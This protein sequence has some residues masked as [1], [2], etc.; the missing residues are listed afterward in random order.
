M[1]SRK[2]IFLILCIILLQRGIKAQNYY[3]AGLGNSNLQLWL[4]AADPTTL[5]T[6]SGAQATNGSSIAKW[7]DKSGRAAN[8][9]Q[10]SGSAK[11]VYKTNQL[12]GFGA[13]IFQ[14]TNQYM[15]GASGAYQTI[16]S[17]RAMLGT[18]YQYL[19]SSPANS[20]F[21]IRFSGSTTT[22]VSYTDGPNGNDWSYNTGTTPSQWINGVKSLTGSTATHILVDQ[23][24]NASNATYSL[25]STFMSRGMYN[26]DPV[27]ELIA[28]NG[29]LNNTQ[30]ILLENYE[31]AEWGLSGNLPSSGYTIFTPPTSSTY[32]KNL[33]GI[34]YT[35][36]SDNFLTNAAG[37]TD[38]L[39]FSSGTTTSDFLKTAGFIM[40][41]HNGQT[42]TVAYN[43]TLNSVPANTYVW[44]R[45][46]YIQKTNGNSSGNVTLNFN[47]NDY[48][49]STPNAAYFYAILYNPSD[50]T[51]TSGTN[52]KI[53]VLSYN[54]SGNVASFIVKASTLATGYYTVIYNQTNTLPLKLESFS[55]NKISAYAVSVNWKT[56]QEINTD[57]FDIQ[58][59]SDGISFKTIGTVSA[60]G[61]SATETNYGFTDNSPEYGVNYY[62]LKMVDADNSFTYS[63]VAMVS[64][65]QTQTSMV[66]YPNP[67]ISGQSVKLSTGTNASMLLVKVHNS[68]GNIQ[69]VQSF[70][71]ASGPVSLNISNLK[72]GMYFVEV[73][74]D[75]REQQLLKLI[76]K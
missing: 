7:L 74:I 35:S 6:S 19:F 4:T 75:N 59:S 26:N 9:L 76:V 52:T 8:A 73:V 15:T 32:N 28:Y 29:T 44:N 12:N 47:F 69:S 24:Q 49:G 46:W 72:T 18:S 21:S 57:H 50:G 63:T 48:N 64:F 31:A 58:R 34:G 54:V 2:P 65:D 66:L 38:G 41:A 60:K 17:T 45:S 40:A 10:N 43:P 70:Q 67:V 33:V 39:G 55:A 37:S 22:S 36:S 27:Y 16:I 13:V 1:Q 25:S 14:N 61:N 62:K 30:R 5:L 42:N 68:S 51:F 20:D 23:S 56:A 53:S 3:P 11:P 71:N